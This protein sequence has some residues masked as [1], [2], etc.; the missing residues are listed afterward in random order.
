MSALEVSGK[1]CQTITFTSVLILSP[2][3]SLILSM[4]GTKKRGNFAYIMFWHFEFC[5][6]VS[7]RWSKDL[8][9]SIYFSFFLGISCFVSSCICS[10]WTGRRQIYRIVGHE[11]TQTE[12]RKFWNVPINWKLA[13]TAVY[14]CLQSIT[15]Y[16]PVYN[17]DMIGWGDNQALR[18]KV[19]IS[20]HKWA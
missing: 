12:Q 20:P 8:R 2:S 6:K 15:V 14:N 10:G 3:S 4:Q 18:A 19:G 5:D 13:H 11:I 17:Q 16:K 7:P 9:H 1:I